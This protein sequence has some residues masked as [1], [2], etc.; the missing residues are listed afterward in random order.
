[1]QIDHL[2][3]PTRSV[4][5]F[6]RIL[7]NR[8]GPRLAGSEACRQ[9]AVA[10]C[11]KLSHI[12]GKAEME[13]FETH[14]LAFMNFYK[15]TVSAYVACVVCVFLNQPLLAALGFVFII[16]GE[17]LEFGFYQEFFDPLFPKQTCR[18][19]WAKL[20]PQETPLRQVILSGHHDSA[21]EL[22]FLR[23][24]Q[25]LL[26]VRAF[27][28]DLFYLIG[29]VLCWGWVFAGQDLPY[30][31]FLR[32]GLAFGLI[33]VV[34]KFFL[35]S[36]KTTPGAGDN[37]IASAMLPELARM[38]AQ[39]GRPGRS[40]LKSTRLIF[41]SFDAEESALRG[42]RAFVNKHRAELHS[43]PTWMLNI[44]S[45]YNVKDL[46]FLVSDLNGFTPLS[47]ATAQECVEIAREAGYP[48]RLFNMLFGGGG[49]DAAEFAKVG[50]KATS[51]LAMPTTVFRE[52]LAYHT[53][54]DTVEAIEP[55]AVRACLAVAKGFVLQKDQSALESSRT[56]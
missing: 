48:A 51:M 11:D 10:L 44:D 23:R 38:F 13:T 28:P 3:A 37:L 9:A 30:I 7:I 18:N 49:T 21:Q 14:P 16:A 26:I 39:A 17:M 55:E 40:W 5:N 2:A 15:I 20:E 4:L 43:L 12:C 6:T 19:V 53:L 50:V 36:D 31:P 29:L 35:V 24:W 46:Q 22:T 1:M 8:F 27:T 47:K 42:S 54:Q 41:V 32:G 34:P 45:I 52:G 33:F 56:A 25:K